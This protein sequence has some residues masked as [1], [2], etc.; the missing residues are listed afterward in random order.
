MAPV[1]G[2]FRLIP[3]LPKPGLVA[4]GSFSGSLA[5]YAT[6]VVAH[7]DALVVVRRTESTYR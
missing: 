3:A 6:L 4:E 1:T 7:T 2:P 5:Q